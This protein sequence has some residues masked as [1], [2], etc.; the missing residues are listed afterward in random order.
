MPRQITRFGGVLQ[1][2]IQYILTGV[3]IESLAFEA[4]EPV[5]EFGGEGEIDSGHPGPRLRARCARPK[6]L[7]RFCRTHSNL[8]ERARFELAVPVRGRRFS[9][10]VHSTALPPLRSLKSI[11]YSAY[12]TFFFMHWLEFYLTCTRYAHYRRQ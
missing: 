2:A 7:P 10:P 5:A 11:S 1:C 4:I 6:S 3:S 9:R 12:R 8:A